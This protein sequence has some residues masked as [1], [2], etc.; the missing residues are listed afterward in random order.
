MESITWWDLADG[1]WLNAPSGLLRRDGSPK[2]AYE[3]LHRL[4]K[5]DWWLPPT[6]LRTGEDGTLRFG[7]FLGDYRLSSRGG[8]SNLYL[9]RPGAVAV[10]VALDAAAEP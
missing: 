1:Q 4:V 6:T 2:P 7:G 5:G 8:T 10:D 3:A 9:D